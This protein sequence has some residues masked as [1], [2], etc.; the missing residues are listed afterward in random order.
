MLYRLELRRNGV[1]LKFFETEEKLAAKIQAKQWIERTQ[2]AVVIL[3]IDGQEIRLKDTAKKLGF[4]GGEFDSLSRYTTKESAQHIMRRARN[5]SGGLTHR[6][7]D[8]KDDV[9]F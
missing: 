8:G 7:K 1:V 3:F 4:K 9:R 5:G 6:P 2:D